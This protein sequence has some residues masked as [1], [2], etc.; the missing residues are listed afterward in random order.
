MEIKDLLGY[1]GYDAEKIKS[2]DDFK[3][4]FEKEFVKTSNLSED[5]PLLGSVL[6][7]VYGKQDHE[8][9]KL[10]KEL[11]IDFDTEEYKAAKMVT[12]KAKYISS[13]LQEKLNAT[14]SELKTKAS[15]GND[16]NYKDLEKKYAKLKQEKADTD[17]LL[18]TTK[19]D[20]EKFQET[21]KNEVKGV[22]LGIKHSDSWGKVKWNSTTATELA[23]KGFLSHMKENYQLDLADDDSLILK[24]KNG[25]RIPSAKRAGEFKSY[26]EVLEEDAIKFGLLQLNEGAKKQTVP[27]NSV[28]GYTPPSPSNNSNERPIAPR[29]M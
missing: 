9:K 19:A 15:Q 21:S 20:F 16:D 11:E 17:N 22:K 13:K 26:D 12:D 29:M 28:A 25:N 14:I 2:L 6:G 8:M 7:K 10:A 27:Q 5:N 1:L 3:P 23:K 24:D 4:A 18:N